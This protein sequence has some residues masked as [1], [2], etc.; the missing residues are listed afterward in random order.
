LY[1]SYETYVEYNIKHTLF[2]LNEGVI[3]EY[4]LTRIEMNKI[5]NVLYSKLFNSG[6]KVCKGYTLDPKYLR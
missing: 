3:T 2:K 6:V 1:K 5:D 4:N